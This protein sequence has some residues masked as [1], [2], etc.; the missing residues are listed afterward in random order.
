MTFLDFTEFL[1]RHRLV[2][3]LVTVD[4]PFESSGL[5]SRFLRFLNGGYFRHG[6]VASR[7]DYLLTAFR[8]RR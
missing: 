4:W 5:A 3:A 7:D 2:K 8:A 6:F 1:L